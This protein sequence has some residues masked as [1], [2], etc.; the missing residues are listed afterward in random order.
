MAK[1]K[2]VEETPVVQENIE[3]EYLESVMEDRFADYTKY[4]IQDRAIPDARDGLKPVQR[5]IVYSMYQHGNVFDKPTKKCASI[6]GNVMGKLHPHG[7]SSIY[8]AL[9]RMSQPW[10][11]NMPLVKFQGNNGSIDNDPAAAYR[12]TEA[13]LN[14]LAMEMVRDL[15]KETV[16]RTWNFDDTE[17]EPIVL[18]ARFPNLYVNGAEGVAV[19]VATSIPPHNLTEMIDAVIYRIDHPHCDID[20][21]LN[22]V[23]GPDFP[24]GGIIYK[25]EGIKD[26]YTTGRGTIELA[27]KV[28]IVEEKDSNSLIISQIPYQV[29][30]QAL[31]VSIDKIRKN[32]DIDGIVEVIDESADE[33]IKIAVVLKKEVDPNIVLTYLYKKTQLKVNINANIVAI[34]NNKPKQ[35]A[36]TDYLDTYIAHQVDVITRRSKHDIDVAKKRLHIVE[37]LIKAISII[38][39]V[40]EAIQKSKNKEDAKINIMQ[41]FGF[42]EPQAEAIVMMRLYVLSNQDITKI[43]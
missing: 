28:D 15:D 40:V 5:R 19:G 21:L 14:E 3:T 1:K 36:L 42:T 43:Y 35:L 27:S 34:S 11:S 41:L 13:K 39:E 16:D 8:E 12:Y 37:G 4:V 33:D 38:K 31:V 20:S 26:I 6:V 9:V 17:K 22:I 23:K 10:K 29:N 25:S 18:P 24:T 2:K 30:K 32:R 7:D